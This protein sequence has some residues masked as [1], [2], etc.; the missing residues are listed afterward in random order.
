[1]SEF[2]SQFTVST[3]IGQ[4]PLTVNFV[5]T[6]T[7]A[8]STV[9]WNFGDGNTSTEFHPSHIYT[10]DG[11]YEAQLTIY[12]NDATTNNISSQ[13]VSVFPDSQIDSSESTEQ[14]NLFVTKRFDPGQVQVI[15]ETYGES[16][17]TT[18]PV[19]NKYIVSVDEEGTPH[20]GQAVAGGGV[21]R[22]MADLDTMSGSTLTSFSTLVDS[23]DQSYLYTWLQANSS[24]SEVGLYEDLKSENCLLGLQLIANTSK[25][26]G[27]TNDGDIGA[28]M[29][30]DLPPQV[31]WYNVISITRSLG[32]GSADTIFEIEVDRPLPWRGEDSSTT[33]GAAAFC[34]VLN[35]TG[36]TT[37]N[38]FDYEG[39]SNVKISFAND[40]SGLQ[41]FLAT[42][43]YDKSPAGNGVALT[44]GTKSSD[45]LGLLK[46]VIQPDTPDVRS[47]DRLKPGSN[48]LRI[49]WIVQ[50]DNSEIGLLLDDSIGEVEID[51]VSGKQFKYM[52]NTTEKI[53][54]RIFYSP[55]VVIID[56]VE[57]NIAIQASSNRNF[58][59]ETCITSEQ[60]SDSGWSES[61][62]TYF[63]TYSPSLNETD[64]NSATNTFGMG[65]SKFYP[66]ANYSVIDCRG[67]L[68][69]FNIT[70]PG[71]DYAVTTNV[72]AGG[73]SGG[74][75]PIE[76]AG[77]IY[78]AT[79]ET[80]TQI[81]PA[82]WRYIE[83]TGSPFYD[84]QFELTT[85]YGDMDPCQ[86]G[87][88]D[89]NLQ[90]L[91]TYP[92]NPGT[93]KLIAAHMEGLVESVSHKI[94]ATCVAKNSEFNQ[95]QNKSHTNG[96]TYIT[97]VGIYNENNDL[98]MIGKLSKP[99]EKDD[100]KYVVIKMELDI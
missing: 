73:S 82:S 15:E 26:Y 32:T 77:F 45:S 9:S 43:D 20:F 67:D 61:G 99:I 53:I 2:K 59:L 40:E 27:P 89:S 64:T 93:E 52:R 71:S 91:G 83:Y 30:E 70:I 56:D 39:E 21:F 44:T 63:V 23:N 96:S 50:H 80:S 62:T 75:I 69:K 29:T 37:A 58:T 47:A 84:T 42:T 57:I 85:A 4:A 49:P 54:G 33:D 8:F 78:I 31:L 10:N 19:D 17:Y 66:C 16:E 1:M 97:E 81:N 5:N 24:V 87:T 36:N 55:K 88:A 51:P 68:S 79:G 13:T 35:T 95:T 86:W 100:S 3:K 74:F 90:L 41:I 25:T 28:A 92:F 11:T 48:Y 7:G 12:N 34:L 72:A 6:S 22:M 46:A 60:I 98:L 65:Y 76:T 38:R 18:A 14:S 94:A